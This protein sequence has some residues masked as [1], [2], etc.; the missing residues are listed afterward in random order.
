MA[1]ATVK[2]EHLS[3]NLACCIKKEMII[4]GGGICGIIAA[5]MCH[6]RNISYILVERQEILGG[7]WHS[8]ANAHSYLQVR[9]NTP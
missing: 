2:I 3:G 5:K 9:F 7:N 1:S 4:I 8:L 6:D